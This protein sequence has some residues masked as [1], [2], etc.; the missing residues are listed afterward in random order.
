MWVTPC[1]SISSKIFTGSTLRRQTLTPEAAA[2]VQGKHQP[3]QWN[4]GSVH[5]YTGC[6][7]RPP[8][9]M[10]LTAFRYAPR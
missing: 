9:R 10:L 6:W 1:V 7:P 3:L 5:R 8:E 2:I 4:I